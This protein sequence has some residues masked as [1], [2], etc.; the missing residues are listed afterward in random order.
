MIS[1]PTGK[2]FPDYGGVY[3]SKYIS[4]KNKQDTGI[5]LIL[6][7][8]AVTV[9]VLSLILSAPIFAKEN[10]DNDSN[11]NASDKIYIQKKEI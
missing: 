4:E 3:L 2:Y 8:F 11:I 1:S 10:T 9:I 7:L 5:N 6:V